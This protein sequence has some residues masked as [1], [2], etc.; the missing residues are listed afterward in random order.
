M[1]FR[2]NSEFA[3]ELIE[4]K[5]FFFFQKTAVK[6]LKPL[7]FRFCLTKSFLNWRENL[8]KEIDMVGVILEAPFVNQ[9]IKFHSVLNKYLEGL[10][11]SKPVFL[12]LNKARN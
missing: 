1:Q 7:C 3:I 12:I 5:T 2:V 6:P 8:L 9:T 4:F 11:E 10:D